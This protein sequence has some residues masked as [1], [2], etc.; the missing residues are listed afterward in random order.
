M[1]P[2]ATSLYLEGEFWAL[3]V[4]SVLVPAAVF[5]WLIRRR[6]ISRLA[7]ASIAVSLVVLSGVDAILLQRLSAMAKST[8]GVGDDRVF[9]SEFS[10]ALYI[11]PLLTAGIGINLLTHVLNRHLIIAE[12]EY[13]REQ[14]QQHPRGQEDTGEKAARGR[15]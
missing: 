15:A 8:P 10:L 3:V 5:I 1:S 13:D 7:V 11:L 2:A 6:K 4:V 14:R 12:L 9:A